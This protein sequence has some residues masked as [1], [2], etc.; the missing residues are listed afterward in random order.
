MLD[1]DKVVHKVS[2]GAWLSTSESVR[3]SIETIASVPIAAGASLLGVLRLEEACRSSAG[4]ET[5][6]TG[7]VPPVMIRSNDKAS[8]M[9]KDTE[10]SELM[11]D[12]PM[13]WVFSLPFNE[14][15]E[16]ST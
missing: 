7:Q 11:V 13:D 16:E 15:R 1:I 14:A 4:Q 6:L 12:P 8:G 2:G 10:P 5:R 3:S 9:P